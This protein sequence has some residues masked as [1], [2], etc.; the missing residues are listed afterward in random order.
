MEYVVFKFQYHHSDH[1]N[2]TPDGVVP[3]AIQGWLELCD[4]GWAWE[5]WL[6][7]EQDDECVYCTYDGEICGIIVYRLDKKLRK[8]HIQ[9]GYVDSKFRGTKVYDNLWSNV[10]INAEKA[11]CHTIE[12]YVHP[13]NHAMIRKLQ[14]QKREIAF[15]L[16]RSKI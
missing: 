14:K 4:N 10:T 11:H 7:F 6:P 1:I 5:P 9:L 13:T 2:G 8:C 3:F 15:Y 12:S 16:I